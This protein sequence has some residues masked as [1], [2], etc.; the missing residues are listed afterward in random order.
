MA[1][2]Y[3]KTNNEELIFNMKNIGGNLIIYLLIMTK[4]TPLLPHCSLF[5][6][7][8]ACIIKEMIFVHQVNKFFDHFP[9]LSVSSCSMLHGN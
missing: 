8:S 6:K 7:Y 2:D 3:T 5:F 4:A 9:L 1:S